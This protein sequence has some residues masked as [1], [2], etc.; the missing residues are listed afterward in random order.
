[1]VRKISEIKWNGKVE[2]LS[3]YNVNEAFVVA[4]V[5]DI[6]PIVLCSV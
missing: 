2:D 4:T 3:F 6:K 1:M 5:L